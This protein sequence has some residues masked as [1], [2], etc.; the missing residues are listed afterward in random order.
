MISVIKFN[1]YLR[2]A[3]R[4]FHVGRVMLGIEEFFDA[5]KPDESFVTG[6]GWTVTD[7]RRK[8]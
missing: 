8:V 3:S 6:R 2:Q 1:N 4:T 7:L 5:K